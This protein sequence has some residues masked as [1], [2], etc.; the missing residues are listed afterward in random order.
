MSNLVTV[1]S[2]TTKDDAVSAPRLFL[3]K[4]TTLKSFI[5]MVSNETNLVHFG[6]SF[7]QSQFPFASIGRQHS[8]IDSVVVVSVTA[9]AVA[10]ATTVVDVAVEV[11]Q[12]ASFSSLPLS[13][14]S[15][16]SHNN[17]TSMHVS[18][19]D[20]SQRAYVY[21]TLPTI[22]TGHSI[23]VLSV[24]PVATKAAAST[25]PAPLDLKYASLTPV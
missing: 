17:P 20:P 15:I 1:L 4:D 16:S 2:D 18:P 10:A 24:S 9:V 6:F 23:F 7:E 21:A 14:S 12:V 8:R 5:A 22:S 13:Q 19:L 3:A 25:F 11:A